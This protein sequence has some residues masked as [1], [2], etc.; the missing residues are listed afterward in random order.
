MKAVL[1]R[2]SY[3]DNI[4]ESDA[5]IRRGEH[6]HQCEHCSKWYWGEHKDEHESEFGHVPEPSSLEGWDLDSPDPLNPRIR[7]PRRRRK[8][9]CEDCAVVMAK[10]EELV[11]RARKRP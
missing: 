10:W 8:R 1:C 11:A 9:P 4:E 6:Q 7:A 3:G 5:R 2:I